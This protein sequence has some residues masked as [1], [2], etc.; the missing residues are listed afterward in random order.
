[1]F[2]LDRQGLDQGVRIYRAEPFDLAGTAR[3][4]TEGRLE[5]AGYCN[6]DPRIEIMGVV[7]FHRRRPVAM[8]SSGPGRSECADFAYAF[9]FRQKIFVE[10]HEFG[11][12]GDGFFHPRQFEDCVAAYNLLG[13]GEWAVYDAEFAAFQTHLFAGGQWHQAGVVQHTTGLDLPFGE[14]VRRSDELWGG[15]AFPVRFN[16]VHNAHD[17]IPL[18]RAADAHRQGMSRMPV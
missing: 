5:M 4:D 3:A 9:P 11:R 2:A 10:L 17:R 6:G 16:D 14:F 15:R 8:A 7:Q 13:L 18:Q 12:L 1:M